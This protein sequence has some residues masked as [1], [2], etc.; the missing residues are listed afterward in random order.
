MASLRAG[1]RS[2]KCLHAPQ[3]CEPNVFTSLKLVQH[4]S[5]I[6]RAPFCTLIARQVE[7]RNYWAYE[8]IHEGRR[9]QSATFTAAT[10][11]GSVAASDSLGEK[12]LKGDKAAA[13]GGKKDGKGKAGGGKKA[14]ESAESTS[15]EEAIRA[16]RIRKVEEM[17]EAGLNPFCY[18]WE[19]SHRAEELQTA[20]MSLGDGEE[21]AGPTD[22][23][24]V[25][26]RV[27][28]RRVFGKLAFLTIRDEAHTIQVSF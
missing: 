18:S 16:G 12:S 8:A 20:Y 22:R 28:A 21:A 7:F 4:A 10:A 17:R 6:F 3:L 5:G 13:S 19:R 23:V 9:R 27:I 1:L 2:Y 11:S 25:A 26:G 15:S 14:Q 24:T